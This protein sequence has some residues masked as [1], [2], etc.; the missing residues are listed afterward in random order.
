MT[1]AMA[2][3]SFADDG[4]SIKVTNA[5]NDITYEAYKIF[6]GTVAT[7]NPN[8]LAY[9]AT[10]AQEQWFKSQPN[11][12][13]AFSSDNGTGYYVTIAEG[14]SDSDVI[15]FLDGLVTRNG[16]ANVVNTAGFVGATAISGTKN[17]TE[18]TF[19]DLDYGYYMVVSGMNAAV[20][21]TPT[22][23]NAEVIDKNQN[24]PSDN[25]N[26][27]DGKFVKRSD[28]DTWGDFTTANY[29]G[30]LNFKVQYSTTNY[31]HADRIIAYQITDTL[32]SGLSYVMT[33]EGENAVADVK[34]YVSA[35]NGGDQTEII[36]A[37][38]SMTEDKKGFTINVPWA[39]TNPSPG[40][41]IIE[42]SATVDND[43]NV[44]D[45]STNDTGRT[46]T[47]NLTYETETEGH[48]TPESMEET[49]TTKT[50]ALAI[51]KTDGAGQPLAGAQFTLTDA[52]NG[53]V[54]V[55]EVAGETGVYSY[56][57]DGT[58]VL[59]SPATGVITIKGV[60]AGTYKVTETVAPNGYNP[61]VG[62]K[63]IEAKVDTVYT[64]TKTV[65][66]DADGNESETVTATY[67]NPVSSV[68]ASM[69]TVINKTGAT[70]PSTGGI[71]TTIFYAA[72]II[73]M[74]GAVFFVVRRKRA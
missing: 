2:A 62:S 41:I 50:Y 29:E 51:S 19:S 33:G 7:S 34:A 5:T 73:L 9:T 71:G 16:N 44:N 39:A 60:Q 54:K 47:A 49:T 52:N 46:N 68:P 13:F 36:G 37:T 35:T 48:K 67:A 1:L 15:S 66:Y 31:D 6:D 70:L 58:G 56:D 8:Q 59:T 32:G 57:P 28:Q 26:D 18:I 12:P 22:V 69:I 42:Y 25:T 72:G 40:K 53:V 4:A 14:K 3:P 24:G 45:N 20:S 43:G 27:G 63:E 38:V 65:Y 11:N 61:L 23:P 21:L 10:A 17:G 30:T 64:T 74:A 55:S